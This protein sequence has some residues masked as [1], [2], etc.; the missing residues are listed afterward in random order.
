MVSDGGAHSGWEHIEACIELAAR[1]GVT[2]LVLHAFTDGRD[3]LPHGGAA[4]VEEVERWLLEHV[5]EV[6][7]DMELG[8]SAAILRAVAAGLGLSCL[9][10]SV[11][12]DALA[13]GAVAAV[14]TGLPPLTRQLR[15]VRH[16]ERPVTRGM[17]A[18]LGS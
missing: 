6:Q 12:A 4:Y 18:F 16:R 15:L 8:D 11:V 2:D 13:A 3:T 5:G 7:V 1:E 14:R 10:A 9:P 17:R